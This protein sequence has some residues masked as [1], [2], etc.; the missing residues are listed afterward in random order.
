MSANPVE[1]TG[2]L[3][4]DVA[5][6]KDLVVAYAKQETV[7]PVKALGRFVGFGVAGSMLLAV[8]L[9]LLVLAILRVLQT[10]TGAVFAGRLSFVPYLA[11]VGACGVVLAL[12]V[13]AIG[14]ARRRTRP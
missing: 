8:G 13:R 2:R 4:G 6:I 5:E 1:R 9:L 10:E 11:T 3:P 7:A 14:A 12:A